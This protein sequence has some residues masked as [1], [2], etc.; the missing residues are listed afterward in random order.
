MTPTDPRESRFVI[1]AAQIR[2]RPGRLAE[3]VE[4][5]LRLAGRA[6]DE[7][8]S[9][10]IFPELSLT[11]YSSALTHRDAIEPGDPMLEPLAELARERGIT[12]VAGAPLAS[13]RGIAIGSVTFG[14]GG[15]RGTYTKRY[16]HESETPVFEPGE[17]GPLLAVAGTPVGLAICAEVNHPAHFPETVASGARI[18]AASSFLSP[19]GYEKDFLRLTVCT[20]T[21]RIPAVMANFADSADL[22]SAGGTAAWDDEGRLLAAAPR[23]AE[24]VV[25]AEL[26]GEEWRGRVV[27]EP[28]RD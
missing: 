28:E 17:G 9:L 10:V 21:L 27:R 15:A 13:G 20:Q 11:G 26:D 7:G 8:A 24:C 2:A 5:H 25:F 4:A 22:E 3:S 23:A 14:A 16:L 6:A 19:R 1:A 18:Y 12:V